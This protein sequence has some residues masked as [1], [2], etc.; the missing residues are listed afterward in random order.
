MS[1]GTHAGTPYICTCSHPE[2]HV[3]CQ[4]QGWAGNHTL[5]RFVRPQTTR[6][7]FFFFAFIPPPGLYSSHTICVWYRVH[8]Y[9][10]AHRPSFQPSVDGW[11]KG[12]FCFILRPPLLP[13]RAPFLSG[14][15]W[16]RAQTVEF[17]FSYFLFF[18]NRFLLRTGRY[19][20]RPKVDSNLACHSWFFPMSQAAGQHRTVCCALLCRTVPYHIVR[21]CTMHTYP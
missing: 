12:R 16:M 11:K 4:I 13:V 19:R 8:T 10:P 14:L 18:S 21:T 17:F 7:C 6:S 3:A 1:L 20:N 15:R 5:P 2:C 9:L